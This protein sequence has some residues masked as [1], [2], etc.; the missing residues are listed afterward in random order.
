M[1]RR[2]CRAAAAL[3]A[4]LIALA[5]AAARAQ[6]GGTGRQPA[7]P[8]VPECRLQ[9]LATV[10][11][12]VLPARFL[13]VSDSLGY[14]DWVAKTIDQQAFLTSVDD[15]LAFALRERGVKG[16]V[17]PNDLLRSARRNPSMVHDPYS[18]LADELREGVKR[19][20]GALHE[21]LASQLRSIVA[22]TEARHVL[23]PVDVRLEK[24]GRAGRASLEYVVIDARRSW[25]TCRG[26]V[27]GD[28]S[29]ALSPAVAASVAGRL[30]AEVI[31]PR[32]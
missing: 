8:A 17:F 24:M 28:T 11:V 14:D 30:A 23:V 2:T 4:L 12:A 25:L 22:L 31:P 1:L 16:W 32:R 21:P 5:P 29:S 18:V 9:S 13:G 3:A 26:R 6:R 20:D 7:R 15:E 27:H 10:P 19:K